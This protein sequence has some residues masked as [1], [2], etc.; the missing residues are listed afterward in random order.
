[1]KE[2]ADASTTVDMQVGPVN[3]GSAGG[4]P[5]THRRTGQAAGLTRMRW[6]R[7][8]ADVPAR[9]RATDFTE[10]RLLRQGL[11]RGSAGNLQA[12]HRRSIVR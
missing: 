8:I 5:R 6:S 10:H 12:A 3:R 4:S 7:L 9:L 11:R 1:M 2:S